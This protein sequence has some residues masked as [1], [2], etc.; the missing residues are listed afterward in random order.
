MPVTWVLESNVFSERCFDEMVDHLQR[1]EYPFHI[2]RIIPFSHELVGAMP[3][4]KGPCVVYGSLGAQRLAASQGWKPGVWTNDDFSS[5][6]YSSKLGEMFLNHGLVRCRFSDVPSKARELD[7][8][9][10]FIKPD[11]DAK[12]FAGTLL[13]LVEIDRWVESLRTSGLLAE[14]D[15]DVVLAQPRSLGREWRTVIVNG[16]VAAFSLYRQYQ[17]VWTDRS[18]DPEARA[19]VERAATLFSPADVYVADVCETDDGMKII[20]Y[21]TFNSAG[22]Y[23]CDA[24]AVIEAVSAW[25]ESQQ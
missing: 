9:T 12:A 23:A 18:I 4:V 20:E 3:N 5:T 6:T 22:L 10:V 24:S 8:R 13:D 16:R 2:V 25:V 21:N 19:A 1:H 14:N 15:F 17:R 7:W 11:S